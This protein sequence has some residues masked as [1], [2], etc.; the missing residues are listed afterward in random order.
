MPEK[1]RNPNWGCPRIAQ[2][3]SFDDKYNQLKQSGQPVVIEPK[4]SKK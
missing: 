2:Q 1:H 4:P 3:I